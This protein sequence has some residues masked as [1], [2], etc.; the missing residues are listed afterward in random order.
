MCDRSS[1][2]VRKC[3]EIVVVGGIREEVSGGNISMS[4]LNTKI[5]KNLY[6]YVNY[7]ITEIMLGLLLTLFKYSKLR[8]IGNVY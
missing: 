5:K 7:N 8:K 1:G 3:E 2:V 6:I 4:F